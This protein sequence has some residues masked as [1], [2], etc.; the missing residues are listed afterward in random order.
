MPLIQNRKIKSAGNVQ[1]SY[2]ASSGREF[3]QIV[4]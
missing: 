2:D 1:M 4:I 3:G